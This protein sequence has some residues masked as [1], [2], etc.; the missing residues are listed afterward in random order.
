MKKLFAFM[1]ALVSVFLVNMPFSG[2]AE[3]AYVAVVPIDIDVDKVERAADFNGYYWDMIIERFQYPEYELL[4][5]E[6]VSAVL[7]DE[8]L[9]SFDQA[10]LMDI[11]QK[12]SAEV[13]I[14]MRITEVKEL[15][16]TFLREPAVQCIMKGELATYN[17]LTGKYYY[18][19]INYNEQIEAVLTVRTD[20]QQKAFA[21]FLRRGINRTLEVKNKKIMK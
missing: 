18:K 6:K 20:W 21:D 11:A 15:P 19:K 2:T 7:P 3:A 9:K 10:S 1:I 16:K 8:G 17:R 4:D 12:V 14:A 13:V 5:D